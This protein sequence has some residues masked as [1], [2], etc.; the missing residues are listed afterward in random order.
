[1]HYF[2]KYFNYLRSRII[3]QNSL[4]T[5]SESL[6]QLI[7]W[8]AR[9]ECFYTYGEIPDTQ[10]GRLENIIL[11]LYIVFRRINYKKGRQND[12]SRALVEYLVDDLDNNLR[13]LGVSD[14]S[15]GKKVRDLV[16]RFYG[17]CRIFDEALCKQTE[18][19][20]KC[21]LLTSIYGNKQ[22]EINADSLNF[23]IAYFLEC[24]KTLDSTDISLLK[25]GKITFPNP[26]ELCA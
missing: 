15:V 13:E 9:K 4:R 20:L 17:R 11:H 19:S 21:A 26:E 7:V 12:L 14:I 23:M 25:K 10:E 5:S 24:I 8:Q 3:L 6:Y 18:E 22:R 2:K 1:M 16:A